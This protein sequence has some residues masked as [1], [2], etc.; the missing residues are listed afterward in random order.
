MAPIIPRTR[1]RVPELV[2]GVPRAHG[3]HA[4]IASRSVPRAMRQ[5]QRGEVPDLLRRRRSPLDPGA[6]ELAPDRHRVRVEDGLGTL[7]CTD[8]NTVTSIGPVASSSVRKM[9]RWPLRIAGVWEATFTPATMT[10]GPAAQRPEICVRVTPR[11]RQERLE[12]AHDVPARVHPQHLELGPHDLGI[13]VVLER[14]SR[15]RRIGERELVAFSGRPPW[16]SRS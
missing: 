2:A 9:I 1:A 15:H 4:A 12:E 7:G 3:P 11:S 10:F 14:V 5:V 6:A 8:S 16:S 13:R